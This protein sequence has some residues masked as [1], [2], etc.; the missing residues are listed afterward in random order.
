MAP[1]IRDAGKRG[2]ANVT[3]CLNP[4]LFEVPASRFPI[5]S[6]RQAERTV[7]HGFVADRGRAG[8]RYQHQRKRACD[9]IRGERRDG[10][11]STAAEYARHPERWGHR[12]ERIGWRRYPDVRR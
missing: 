9:A 8:L 1:V 5:V 12:I 3:S 6:E 10:H 11:A 2:E 7:D 4:S